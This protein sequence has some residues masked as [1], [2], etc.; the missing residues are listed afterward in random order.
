VIHVL[1][2]RLFAR[3]V[4]SLTQMRV[5]AKIVSRLGAVTY[6]TSATVTRW[7]ARTALNWMLRTA[8]VLSQARKSAHVDIQVQLAAGA[9]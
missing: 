6:V 2:T 9:P 7:T 8:L 3:M 1:A 5:P 4:V